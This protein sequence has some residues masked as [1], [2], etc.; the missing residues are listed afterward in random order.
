MIFITFVQIFDFS[1]HFKPDLTCLICTLDGL[2]AMTQ[3]AHGQDKNLQQAHTI[4]SRGN[5]ICYCS[6]DFFVLVFHSMF[7]SVFHA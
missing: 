4:Q 1:E 6:V 2:G 3:L 7:D 5:R